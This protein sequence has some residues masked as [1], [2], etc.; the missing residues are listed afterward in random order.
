MLEASNLVKIFIYVYIRSVQVLV[1]LSHASMIFSLIF[2][3]C[4]SKINR[5]DFLKCYIRQRDAPIFSSK[6]SYKSIWPTLP[7]GKIKCV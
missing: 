1:I 4:I 6:V 7:A 3:K 5:N 2:M